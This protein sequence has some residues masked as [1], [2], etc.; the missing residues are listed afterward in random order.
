MSEP[1]SSRK[2]FDAVYIPVGLIIVGVIIVK[3]EWTP[4]S[5]VLALALGGWK[6]LSLRELTPSL[7]PACRK[8]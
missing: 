1:L 4:Y 7:H 8:D 2:Y 6:F 5:V 3:R